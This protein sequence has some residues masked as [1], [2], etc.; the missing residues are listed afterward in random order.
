[1]TAPAVE[2]PPLAALPKP[3]TGDAGVE[4]SRRLERK[5]LDVMASIA[6]T[7]QADKS[8]PQN[9]YRYASLDAVFAHLRRPLIDAGILIIPE[10]AGLPHERQYATSG[11]NQRTASTVPARFTFVDVETGERLGPLEWLGGGQDDGEKGGTKG[12]TN[13][14]R[15][16]LL[17]FFQLSQAG[18]DGDRSQQQRSGPKNPDK[19]ASKPQKDLIERLARDL[20]LGSVEFMNV[21]RSARGMEIINVDAN[22]AKNACYE[23][24]GNITTGQASHLIDQLN[25]RK[26]ALTQ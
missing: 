8:G 2:Q 4:Q 17:A 7:V 23:H 18:T 3:A 1:M 24:L 21:L 10:G 20:N 26:T 5:L 13:A 19:P 25:D 15:T 11:G 22:T 9:H 16:F 6:P 14:Q 12:L